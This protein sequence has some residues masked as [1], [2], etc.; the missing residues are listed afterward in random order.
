[1]CARQ[2]VGRQGHLR[3]R[4]QLR[5]HGSKLCNVNVLQAQL[6]SGLQRRLEHI[7]LS[8]ALSLHLL[9]NLFFPAF[10]SVIT[11]LS[12]LLFVVAAPWASGSPIGQT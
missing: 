9:M 5:E 8:L 2:Y 10:A 3:P 6:P 7:T 12:K 11:K 1:M 4:P